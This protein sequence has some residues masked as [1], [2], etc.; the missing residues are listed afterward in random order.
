L[1]Q[2]QRVHDEPQTRARVLVICG[3]PR[4]DGSCPGEVSK[5]FRLATIAGET[6][7]GAGIEV[8]ELDLSLLTSEYGRRI[9]PC[10]GCVSTAM[11][12]CH[13]PCSCYP[14]HALDQVDDWMAEIYERWVAAH[15]VLIVT[16]VHWYQVPSVLKLMIDRLVCTDG[17]NPDP[18]STQG[19]KAELAKAIE[20][21]GWRYP[22]HLAGR[23]YGVVV[24]G[25]VAG[26]EGVRRALS[27]WLS[28]MGLI[29]AGP[30]A[31][32]DRMIGYYQP[33]A[34][35][36]E[37]LDEDADVQ[38]EVRNAAAALARTVHE[39]RSGRLDALRSKE[40]RPRPK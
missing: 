19:K 2:A 17:G 3:S 36:H 21:E 8:D 10:E 20:L 24:H 6:L 15:G 7:S 12:L 26:I 16:P 5:S 40:L 1:L 39:L 28:W 29:S 13:W 34:T 38:Q 9:H 25:D 31:Q 37:T 18:T 23:A 35:S 33:Y 30:Q 14:N 4:N 11:P 27:D 22:K 32:L